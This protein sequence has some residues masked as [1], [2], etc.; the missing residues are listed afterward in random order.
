MTLLSILPDYWRA[1]YAKSEIEGAE[2][3]SERLTCAFRRA[4][5]WVILAAGSSGSAIADLQPRLGGAA[6]YDTDLNITWLTNA[7]L[8]AT[9]KF[10]TAGINADGSMPWSTALNW[11]TSMNLAKYLGFSSWRLPTTPEPDTTCPASTFGCT[12]SEMGHLFYIELGGAG[13]NS[14]SGAHNSN[15]S[16]FTNLQDSARCGVY[17]SA[18]TWTADSRQAWVL[19]FCNGVQNTGTKTESAFVL[20]VLTGDVAASSVLPQFAFGGGWYSALY[21]TN[22]GTSPISFP[23]NFISDAGTPLNVPSVGGSSIMVNLAARGTAIIEAP[24][25]GPLIQGYVS[26][27]LPSGVQ[28]YGVFRQ[29]A[30]GVPDQEA[31]VPLSSA[32]S[33]TATLTWDETNFTTGV[34]IVNP[35][36]VAA[37]VTITVRDTNG[38]IIGS[39]SLALSAKS[40]MAAALRNLPGLG[41]MP[42]NR[43]SADFTVSSGS[44]AVLGLR[45]GPTAFTSIPAGQR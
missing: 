36:A 44:V 2:F 28:S 7:N 40:K 29:S 38:L 1:A 23:V 32:F 17:W 42:G 27:S 19:N 10:G 15:F 14:I 12:G 41:G 26:L 39:S 37:A 9:N 3:R 5:L 16:L 30:P 18:N 4:A 45:F 22:T 6:V 20:P 11:I 21:F 8:A 13:G 24:N 43:G 25:A 33:T 35:S 31:V 34:A